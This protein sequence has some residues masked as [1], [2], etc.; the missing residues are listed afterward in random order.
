MPPKRKR[1]SVRVLARAIK[2][3]KFGYNRRLKTKNKDLTFKYIVKNGRI[4]KL[5]KF[6]SMEQGALVKTL[7][8][9]ETARLKKPGKR[10]P[11]KSFRYLQQLLTS[12]PKNS[13]MMFLERHDKFPEFYHFCVIGGRNVWIDLSDNLPFLS[14]MRP[15]PKSKKS[16]EPQEEISTTV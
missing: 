15:P 9:I 8:D 14:M 7:E 6:M 5:D 10:G 2:I 12:V 4:P 1:R 16:K 3:S 11:Y 13:K